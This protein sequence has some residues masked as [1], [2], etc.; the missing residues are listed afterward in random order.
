MP[1]LRN[2]WSVLSISSVLPS[3]IVGV[4]D[5]PT[6]VSSTSLFGSTLHTERTQSCRSAMNSRPAGAAGVDAP[7]AAAS[8]RRGSSTN[9][10]QSVLSE[11]SRTACR[12][13]PP[14][15]GSNTGSGPSPSASH[16]TPT[17]AVRASATNRSRLGSASPFSHLRNAE[18]ETPIERANRSALGQCVRMV[19]RRS[20]K[21]SFSDPLPRRSP[22]DAAR[23]LL[24]RGMF[25][26][27]FSVATLSA[28][29]AIAFP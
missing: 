19:C 13:R 10:L 9:S 1:K 2:V 12:R 14:C 27:S 3:R 26:D 17:P 8:G 16:A 28:L 29:D 11:T 23:V 7:A 24:R 6:A 4:I 15:A 22:S 18:G 21:A 5:S 25:T 20:T